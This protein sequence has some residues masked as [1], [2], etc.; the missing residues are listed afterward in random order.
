[1]GTN[2]RQALY[3]VVA[4]GSL[5]WAWTHGFAWIAG[6]GN[7]L[8]LP[9]FFIDAY[10]SGSAAAFLTVDILTAWG[11]FIAWVITD[12]RRIGLG[13]G[14]GVGF[15]LLSGLGTCF[16]FPLYLVKRERFLDAKSALST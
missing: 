15:A 6:G 12:A 4:F 11:V 14:W 16:A 2:L 9:S 5:I 3:V 8:N 7:I 13:T 10:Q 1:M